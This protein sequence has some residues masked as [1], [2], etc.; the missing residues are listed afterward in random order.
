MSIEIKATNVALRVDYKTEGKIYNDNANT[1]DG[2]QKSNT[3]ERSDFP[4]DSADLQPGDT[5]VVNGE[6]IRVVEY[7]PTQPDPETPEA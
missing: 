3:A 4:F 6:V 7:K 5:L 1:E 2:V